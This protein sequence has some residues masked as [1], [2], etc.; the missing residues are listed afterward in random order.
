M[1]NSRKQ[2]GK[3]TRSKC[4]T[5]P[6][7]KHPF[8]ME[9]FDRITELAMN[10]FVLRRMFQVRFAGYFISSVYAKLKSDSPCGKR[11]KFLRSNDMFLR[12]NTILCLPRSHHLIFS[13]SV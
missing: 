2:S 9:S 5:V 12:L 6:R 11:K 13:L 10:L 1:Y 8:R 4:E 7:M 3:K